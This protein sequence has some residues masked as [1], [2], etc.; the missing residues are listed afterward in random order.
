MGN[1]LFPE[2]GE[3][4][5]L[6]TIGGGQVAT[7]NTVAQQGG[8]VT[9]RQAEIIGTTQ[10]GGGL[11]WPADLSESIV[12]SLSDIG[13][14]SAM[15]QDPVLFAGMNKIPDTKID[16]G[17]GAMETARA[18]NPRL[19]QE[20]LEGPLAQAGYMTGGFVGGNA[21]FAATRALR[22]VIPGTVR[23]G[24]EMMFRQPG[25]AGAIDDA[26]RMPAR[27][28]SSPALPP[29]QPKLAGPTQSPRRLLADQSLFG[30]TDDAAEATRAA[31]RAQAAS[32]PPVETVGSGSDEMVRFDLNELRGYRQTN[33]DLPPDTMNW[34]GGLKGM[35][36]GNVVDNQ[37]GRRLMLNEDPE[38][39]NRQSVMGGTVTQGELFGDIQPMSPVELAERGMYQD[40]VGKIR[41]RFSDEGIKLRFT[42]DSGELLPG[43]EW[44]LAKRRTPNKDNREIVV[45][46]A[47]LVWPQLTE[48]YDRYPELKDLKVVFKAEDTLGTGGSYVNRAE[49]EIGVGSDVMDKITSA[50]RKKPTAKEKAATVQG[51]MFS[52][53][54][55]DFELPREAVDVL[56]HEIQHQ[57]QRLDKT[58]LGGDTTPFN[59]ALMGYSQVPSRRARA[60]QVNNFKVYTGQLL[61]LYDKDPAMFEEARGYANEIRILSEMAEARNNARSAY[62][63][64]LN[65]YGPNEDYTKSVF[66]KWQN[67]A[68]RYVDLYDKAGRRERNLPSEV[69]NAVE[70]FRG[71]HRLGGSDFTGH[72]TELSTS[73]QNKQPGLFDD[74]DFGNGS[75]TAGLGYTIDDIR[76]LDDMLEQDPDNA[77]R[78]Y[79][80]I[81]GEAEARAMQNLTGVPEGYGPLN[82]EDVFDIPAKQTL[83]DRAGN[84]RPIDPDISNKLPDW[85]RWNMS[86]IQPVTDKDLSAKR[87]L[88][89][90]ENI[91]LPPPPELSPER[92][93]YDKASVRE[94]TAADY[95]AKPPTTPAEKQFNK[96]LSDYLASKDEDGNL[97][98]VMSMS[99]MKAIAEDGK[100]DGMTKKASGEAIERMAEEGKL[101]VPME[102]RALEVTHRI[103]YNGPKTQP[104][105]EQLLQ[106]IYGDNPPHTGQRGYGQT[107]FADLT[108][109]AKSTVGTDLPPKAI[110]NAR[111]ILQDTY[112]VN[113]SGLL[114]KN[115]KLEKSEAGYKGA[116]V[117]APKKPLKTK[118]G[119]GVETTGMSLYQ[120]YEEPGINICPNSASCKDSCLGFTAGG[121]F[122]YGGGSD[123]QGLKGPRLTHFLETQAMLRDPEAFMTVLDDEVRKA[124]AKANENGNVLGIRLNT[125]SDIPPKVYKPLMEKY[126]DVT[127][128][129]YTKLHTNKPIAPNHHLTYSSTGVS[130][131]DIGA[132]N[133]HQNWG[134]MRSRLDEGYNVAMA[135]SVSSKQALPKWVKDAETGKTYEVIDGDTHDFRPADDWDRK[136][137]TGAVVGLRNKD[138]TFGSDPAEGVR[139]EPF[140]VYYD[141]SKGDTVNIPVQSGET[142][143]AELATVNKNTFLMQYPHA[144]D[145]ADNAPLRKE[146]TG[147]TDVDSILF[148]D[149][150]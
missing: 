142:V 63:D 86:K 47:S 109:A 13:Q 51:D 5:I 81:Y 17:F 30:R 105:R 3:Y 139:K 87:G 28:V 90:E 133:P 83:Y 67:L 60:A 95:W 38:L 53:Q 40:A 125:L 103:M 57:I 150:F 121:N 108:R 120:A 143:P 137:N 140:F 88:M 64:A 31:A 124:L 129:D 98:R 144:L 8:I 72:G 114:S 89:P 127:F 85:N 119:R 110:T 132:V 44:N 138:M 36:E 6:D 59:S 76:T 148:G 73:K 55:M 33:S 118:D 100:L 75:S 9:P 96:M 77:F 65:A 42:D 82:P 130:N 16:S 56:A 80:S 101:T 149:E 128:Y 92:K 78:I 84:Y 46:K 52:N 122:A 99:R 19:T 11:G 23:L 41:Q 1:W 54:R 21:P 50:H 14:V 29:P 43:V 4:S 123:L 15:R 71:V 45:N 10:I 37:T 74:L 7:A 2:D 116:G 106:S 49:I 113:P 146:L 25:M 107:N 147:E 145:Y 26:M 61:N 66:K 93:L 27:N 22:N 58:T 141:P 20:E 131:P 18:I 115:L 32:R 94:A 79:Q 69:K 134:H 34:T 39:P 68:E 111:K 70:G 112:G 91:D 136:S 135:F 126:P 97:K 35:R 117:N 104:Q 24:N 102:P 12:G 62:N 48:L